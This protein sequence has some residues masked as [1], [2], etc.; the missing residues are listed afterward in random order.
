MSNNSAAPSPKT[1]Y[2]VLCALSVAHLLNDTFQSLIPAAFPLLKKELSLSYL[3]IGLIMAVFQLSSS[4]FQPLVGWLNDKHPQTYALPL[5]M[6]STLFG[7]LLFAYAGSFPI[8]LIAVALIGLGSAVFH[9]EAARLTFMA[10]GGRLAFAQSLFQTGGNTGTSLA[11]L[12]AAILITPYGQKNIAWFAILVCCAILWMIPLSRWYGRRLKE[13]ELS[14]T[15]AK[16]GTEDVSPE[17]L[18]KRT[19]FIAISV[20][21]LLVFSKNLYTI[22]L[23]IFLPFY[24]IEKFGISEEQSLLFLSA[25]L[26]AAAAGT[27]IGGPIGDKVGRKWVIWFSILG[28]APFALLLPHV[29]SLWGTCLLSMLIGAIIASSFPAIVI[30]A[31]E[32]MP[33]KVGTVGGLFFGFSFGAG[34]IASAFLGGLADYV[35]IMIVYELCSYLPLIGLITWFLPNTP[36]MMNSERGA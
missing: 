19:V 17:T 11:P 16:N 18:P 1:I 15:H 32:L 9:P 34:A 24:F 21:L 23:S 14:G 2:I 8:V 4:I 30:F 5:G 12:L 6:T 36:T 22:S 29:H 33:G 10:S 20:L 31:Q 3:Q 28:V 27:M 25:F 13:K 35:G 26:F 7:I